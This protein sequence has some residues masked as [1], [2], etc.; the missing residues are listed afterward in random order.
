MK[1]WNTSGANEFASTAAEPEETGHA[2]VFKSAKIRKLMLRV[3][4]WEIYEQIFLTKEGNPTTKVERAREKL[5][6]VLD[7]QRY[8]QNKVE[9]VFPDDIEFWEIL[10]TNLREFENEIGVP[11]QLAMIEASLPKTRRKI[12]VYTSTDRALD[13][14]VDCFTDPFTQASE[15]M[16]EHQ[17][18]SDEIDFIQGM[19]QHGIKYK[20]SCVFVLIYLIEMVDMVRGAVVE[21]RGELVASFYITLTNSH[22]IE[23]LKSVQH[24]IAMVEH[25]LL[26][27]ETICGKYQKMKAV[28]EG[29]SKKKA[30]PSTTGKR[31]P[32]D[33]V[34]HT[35]SNRTV[36]HFNKL[37]I[38]ER[39]KLE[40]LE[41]K[42]AAE[43]K[44]V[45]RLEDH[46]FYEGAGGAEASR[47]SAGVGSSSTPFTPLKGTPNKSTGGGS[48]SIKKG[49]RRAS[50]SLRQALVVE[51]KA[52][53]A[54]SFKPF[55]NSSLMSFCE[56]ED[57]EAEAEE[58]ENTFGLSQQ[59]K[60]R[61]ELFK[62]S[63]ADRLQLISENR[64]LRG[65]VN[66]V[67]ARQMERML[68]DKDPDLHSIVSD[69]N[70]WDCERDELDGEIDRLMH[71]KESLLQ[72]LAATS[73]GARMNVKVS[74]SDDDGD[75]D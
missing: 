24:K 75:S 50:V 35:S 20:S 43:M 54:K 1:A 2:K 33:F 71:Q 44:K 22:S 29:S 18:P 12:E 52:A 11:P 15:I 46:E 31:D 61:K 49:P 38:D 8:A 21:Q 4:L 69:L 64:R 10:I 63:E 72:K 60:N 74:G 3:Y 9:L 30:A 32:T 47:L 65:E 13:T 48:S 62:K 23:K 56:D 17:L 39:R 7:G 42:I 14:I 27:S 59:E 34:A 67:G 26:L 19:I 66:E 36:V 40:V 37:I 51:P 25:L 55:A 5:V 6:A 16:V 70:L 53:A 28:Y 57:G 45:G 68:E 73:R 58:E 41:K